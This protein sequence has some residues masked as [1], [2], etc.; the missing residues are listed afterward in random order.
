ME[1]TLSSTF[2]NHYI[3][4][5]EGLQKN[6]STSTKNSSVP[7]T[8]NNN[9]HSSSE[10]DDVIFCCFGKCKIPKTKK[11]FSQY[12]LSCVT[13]MNV[14]L[15]L[16]VL[17][18]L[19]GLSSSFILLYTSGDRVLESTRQFQQLQIQIFINHELTE[20]I[21]TSSLM[22]EHIKYQLQHLPLNL[23]DDI[24]WLRLFQYFYAI[25]SNQVPISGV[26]FGKKNDDIF[27]LLVDDTGN[28]YVKRN[29]ATNHMEWYKTSIKDQINYDFFTRNSTMT[30]P[31]PFFPTP[32]PWFKL[33]LDSSNTLPKWSDL[34]VNIRDQWSLTLSIPIYVNETVTKQTFLKSP[35]YEDK[36]NPT[37]NN[38]YG[39][40]G[41]QLSLN[42]IHEFI[43]RT[44][45]TYYGTL[46][47]VMIIN[48]KADV[49]AKTSHYSRNDSK[50]V[51]NLILR[52]IKDLKLLSLIHPTVG[53]G[54]SSEISV[55]N[56]THFSVSSQNGV[57]D[58]LFTV[59][60][61]YY[62]LDWAIV[63]GVPSR[64]FVEEIFS[65]GGIS[66]AISN[67]L[68]KI[69]RRMVDL[70]HFKG[71]H[72]TE[73]NR[74][75]IF[76][77]VRNMQKSMKSMRRGIRTFSKYVPEI[78]VKQVMNSKHDSEY[79]KIGMTLQNMS[80][81][82]S[83]I[84]DFTSFAEKT[85]T[86][87]FLSVMTEYFSAMCQVMEDNQGL[88]DKFIGDAVLAFFNESSFAIENHEIHACRSALDSFNILSELNTKW[89]LCGY[90]ELDMR[91]GINSGNMLCGNIGA[92]NR[93]NFTV[94]GDAVNIAAR[95]EAL[96]KM[97]DTKILIGEDT[98]N[99]VKDEFICY[100]VDYIVVKGKDKAIAVY[101]LVCDIKNATEEQKELSKDMEIIK[102]Q[103]FSFE[104]KEMTE[105]CKEVYQK[106]NSKIVEN[107]LARSVNL[108]LMKETIPEL[109]VQDISLRLSAK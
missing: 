98:Y 54:D 65:G 25:Y 81:F 91:I 69:A 24:V 75:S 39:V 93:M 16:F 13:I 34:F 77:D 40:V 7:I 59:I 66:S 56:Q 27:N 94:I 76:Y 33:F 100:F 89:K 86:T 58:V 38:L 95:L 80:V 61:D 12:I 44:F 46:D 102:K 92:E 17:Q 83:D 30:D 63:I 55:S 35:I 53:V 2:E 99:K 45:S 64:T 42:R 62:G 19:F 67:P 97:F 6:S 11:A 82:F 79:G 90:S 49:V 21:K 20:F 8:N 74:M 105:N 106:T 36:S 31:T 32:R 28:Y 4:A 3:A 47:F 109:T 10:Q 88:V 107:L 71:I 87:T 15:L 48:S 73:K 84:V 26:Y 104:F 68:Q 85:D 78:I 50:I 1:D 60:T 96:N 18:G 103:F 52:E 43:N 9:H 22:A 41:I 29:N 72:K 14:L 108:Q 51:E 23:R 57:V 70:V 101:S 5:D 37:P